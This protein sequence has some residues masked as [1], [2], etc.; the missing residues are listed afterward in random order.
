MT[1]KRV[2]LSSA[3]VAMTF[4]AQAAGAA[5]PTL[6][7]VLGNSGITANGWISGSYVYG[8]NDDQPALAGRTF[9][10]DTDSFLFNQAVL[11]I[12]SLP[13]EG[14]GGLVTLLAGEDAVGI[15]ASY[16]D[17]S[18]DKYT[19]NQAYFQYAS[20]AL[21]VIGGRFNTLAGAEVIAD[22]LNANLSRSILFTFVEPF[23]HTGV[24]ASY[25][26]S[27]MFTAYLGVNN[28]GLG[29]LSSDID[30]R[31][32]IELGGYFAPSSAI[33][34]GVY[35]YYGV[36]ADGVKNNYIDL[37]ATWQVMDA[38]QLVLNVDNQ[39]TK[40]EGANK[41]KK[42][43]GALYANY[44]ISDQFRASIRGEIVKFDADDDTLADDTDTVK[45]ITFTLGYS[46]AKN[47][48][49]LFEARLDKDQ[50][51]VFIDGIKPDTGGE[52]ASTGGNIAKS[53]TVCDGTDCTKFTD[54]QSDVAIKAIY[55]FGL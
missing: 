6:S 15:N 18:G 19:V 55:K 37:V 54:T 42:T 20:G 38:L 41:P 1:F 13:T 31:K 36:E 50:E 4:G 23:V 8:F 3:V 34:L 49:V 47:F 21:T 52:Q 5:G 39:T 25:K 12:S 17:N 7:E 9:D 24:R 43:G 27:D 32:T 48:D 11:N 33:G 16:G 46:P 35:D 10:G 40:F 29:G 26:V 30:Q 14:F 44:K 51:D 2:L 22:P 28:S 53:T 45:E